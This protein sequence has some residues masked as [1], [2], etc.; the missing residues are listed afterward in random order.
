MRLGEQARG[1]LWGQPA[2]LEGADPQPSPIPALGPQT[3]F[4]ARPGSALLSRSRPLGAVRAPPIERVHTGRILSQLPGRLD[5]RCPR[6][7]WE[8]GRTTVGPGFHLLPTLTE[9][10]PPRRAMRTIT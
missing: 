2:G 6:L 7:G 9:L 8:L 4:P 3:P 5:P 1:V 10:H